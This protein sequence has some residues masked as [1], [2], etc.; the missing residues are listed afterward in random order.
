[1]AY[2]APISTS[3]L[4]SPR[5][6]FACISTRSTTPSKDD[7]E[8]IGSCMTSGFAPRRLMMVSTVK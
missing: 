2:L 5:Q 8:P 6:V 3:P 1:M 4:E 7:S